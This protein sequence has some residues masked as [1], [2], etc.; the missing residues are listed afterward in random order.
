M[1]PRR[2]LLLR[3]TLRGESRLLFNIAVHR[4][5]LPVCNLLFLH[6]AYISG[7]WPDW[8]HLVGFFDLLLLQLMYQQIPYCDIL[9]PRFRA[10][11]HPRMNWLFVP[12]GLVSLLPV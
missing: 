5:L 1:T 12:V 3:R 6:A 11:L 9:H 8:P 2:S 7:P 10:T 4:G